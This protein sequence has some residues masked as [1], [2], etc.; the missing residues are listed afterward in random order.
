MLKWP[1]MFLGNWPRR[2]NIMCGKRPPKD[3]CT[4]ISRTVSVLPWVIKG[5]CT[6]V[7][8]RLRTL[9]W[10]YSVLSEWAQSN[11]TKSLKEEYFS[12]LWW[13]GDV[14]SEEGSREIRWC[15]LWGRKKGSITQGMWV[16]SRSW[17]EQ[18]NRLLLRGSRGECI[19]ADTLVL[20]QW[21]THFGY[22]T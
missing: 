12:W 17:K 18:G 1:I 6:Q 19:C 21:E 4:L 7:W 20:A 3:V 8:L 16:A 9:S 13:E 15:W 22:L 2:D 11:H 5:L 10:D 14:T